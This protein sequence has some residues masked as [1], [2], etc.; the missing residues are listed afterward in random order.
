MKLPW[1]IIDKI[2]LYTDNLD[3][4]IKLNRSYCIKY[5]RE[6]IT[7]KFKILH[8]FYSGRQET[9]LINRSELFNFKD[10]YAK[11]DINFKEIKENNGNYN[12]SI[13]GVDYYPNF[14]NIIQSDIRVYMKAIEIK[15]FYKEYESFNNLTLKFFNPDKKS[16]EYFIEDIKFTLG[17]SILYE[18]H[19]IYNYSNIFDQLF[20]RYIKHENDYTYLPLH[21]I[22]DN[23]LLFTPKYHE[24]VINIKTKNLLINPCLQGKRYFTDII[25]NNQ[26]QLA[27]YQNLKAKKLKQTINEKESILKLRSYHTTNLIYL[28]SETNNYNNIKKIALKFDN[29]I[30][31]EV[32]LDTLKHINKNL[33]YNFSCPVIIF[34]NIFDKYSDTTINLSR[35]DNIEIII[36]QNYIEHC[37]NYDI[38]TVSNNIIMIQDGMCCLRMAN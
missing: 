15:L 32:T 38:Y 36:T 6:I 7:N 8:L 27:I 30:V 4:A 14:G 5:L 24:I 34:S 35:I 22:N 13:Q 29:K 17:G 21:F 25:E 2:I 10:Y 37:E 3:L 1:E 9:F 23:G 26:V 33:G 18:I 16:P 28:T 12:L 20:K 19:D 31:F 11:I